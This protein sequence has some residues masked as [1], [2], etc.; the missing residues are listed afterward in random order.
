MRRRVDRAPEAIRQAA[1]DW[2]SR[3]M[4]GPLSAREDDQLEQWLSADPKHRAAY[5]RAVRLWAEMATLRPRELPAEALAPLPRE[6]MLVWI[7]AGW[8]P[9]TRRLCTAAA[10]TML[11]LLILPPGALDPLREHHKADVAEL[12]E[13]ALEDGSRVTLGAQA[14]IAT[15]LEGERR[16][17]D[18]LAG[19]A[20]FAV[21]HDPKR[22]FVVR[23][24]ETEITVVGTAF[25]LRRRGDGLRLGVTEGA[26]RVR[27][28]ERG[29]EPLAEL[30]AG[31]GIAVSA[32]GRAQPI[33]GED[34]AALGAWRRGRLVYKGAP[35]SEVIADV[36]RYSETWFLLGDPQVAALTITA[37]FDATNIEGMIATLTDALPISVWRPVGA[38]AVIGSTSARDRD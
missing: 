15:R 38:V 31:E 9:W 32:T 19:E 24:G 13:V 16:H 22:P 30:G 17:V 14:H 20:F 3:V 23:V 26:V 36:N 10:L 27:H 25:D 21:T 33:A 2:H 18:L 4:A 8:W 12:R 37:S 34:L 11:A 1:H 7:R 29:D 6:R 35:L 5:D 28:P